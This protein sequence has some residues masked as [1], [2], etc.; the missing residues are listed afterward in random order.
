MSEL[1]GVKFEEAPFEDIDVNWKKEYF[2]LIERQRNEQWR[3]Q[4]DQ[5]YNESM[6]ELNLYSVTDVAQYFRVSRATAYSYMRQGIIPSFQ[7]G[8]RWFVHGYILENIEDKARKLFTQDYAKKSM[9][10]MVWRYAKGLGWR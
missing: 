7:W 6:K 5:V 9:P 8:R 2:D 3:Q 10:R 1:E 4:T